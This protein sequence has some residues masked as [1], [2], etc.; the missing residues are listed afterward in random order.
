MSVFLRDAR[1]CSLT[2]S[3]DEKSFHIHRLAIHA[4]FNPIPQTERYPDG[5]RENPEWKAFDDIVTAV[6]GKTLAMEPLEL[7]PSSPDILAIPFEKRKSPRQKVLPVRRGATAEVLLPT[8]TRNRPLLT[9][10]NVL[11]GQGRMALPTTTAWDTFNWVHATLALSP[12]Q[13]A[14]RVGSF[15]DDKERIHLR[16]GVE[17]V[18]I[19]SEDDDAAAE[20][21]LVIT[22]DAF[23]DMTLITDA[24][25]PVGN[26]LFRMA[27][28]GLIPP[29]TAPSGDE[30]RA[31]ALRDFYECLRPAPDLP[32][33][34]DARKLQPSGMVSKL[35]PFQKRTLALL[36]RNEGI[37][38]D[39]LPLRS[40][41]GGQ[42][43]EFEL[44][45]FG[46]Y[47]FSRLTG[48]LEQ[49]SGR[50]GKD[51][52]TSPSEPSKLFQ[53][54]PLNKVHGTMLCEEMGKLE[55]LDEADNEDSVRQLRLSRSYSS[56]AIP[57]PFP[58]L[59]S[60]YTQKIRRVK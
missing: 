60:R 19:P 22:I 12:T 39:D 44:D 9:I 17:A 54:F 16:T 57:A 24:L 45:G 51:R 10:P 58:V 5:L 49:V 42:W 50:K 28:M 29:N 43:E 3:V 52:A 53:L 13:G 14:T 11:N 40:Y 7:V 41:P 26:D 56:I 35:L 55:R 2:L 32:L 46:T 4:S 23:L 48:L 1:S 37:Q 36:L 27:L 15:R 38:F 30:D 31:S 34:S 18:W 20:L 8:S 47:A 59:Q 21:R 33:H 6:K 25:P